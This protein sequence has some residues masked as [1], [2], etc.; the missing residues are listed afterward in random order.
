LAVRWFFVGRV[1]P[2]IPINSQLF[3]DGYSSGLL[4]V[5]IGI[6]ATV[7]L[8][9]YLLS[10]KGDLYGA[11]LIFMLGLMTLVPTI[12]NLYSNLSVSITPEDYLILVKEK[13]QRGEI[14]DAMKYLE[15]YKSKIS[16]FDIHARIDKRMEKLKEELL[17]NN[18]FKQK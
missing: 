9:A 4:L 8:S 5:I 18:D 15:T 12:A 2:A 3:S 6:I 7:L 17:R 10:K 16:N 14:S 11:R 13:E 1:S